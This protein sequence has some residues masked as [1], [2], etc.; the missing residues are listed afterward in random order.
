MSEPARVSMRWSKPASPYRGLV[1]KVVLTVGGQ[2]YEYLIPDMWLV[3]QDQRGRT[4]MQAVMCWHE[5]ACMQQEW[6]RQQASEPVFQ[7]GEL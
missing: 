2:A 1:R 5:Q 6:E 4:I 3:A 7:K